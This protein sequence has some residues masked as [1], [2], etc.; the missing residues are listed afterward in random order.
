MPLVYSNVLVLD[1]LDSF[2][3]NL[4]DYL[5]RLGAQVRVYRNTVPAQ[6]LPD[7]FDL[8]LLSP[9]PSRP[10]NAGELLAVIDRFHQQKPVL[11]VCLGHQALVHYFGGRVGQVPPQHGK[12]DTLIHDGKTLFGGLPQQLEVARYHSLA[13]LEVPDSMEVS[14]RSVDGT[15]MAIRHKSLPIEGVQ[16]HPESVLSMKADAGMRMLQN[17]LEGKLTATGA[18]YTQLIGRLQKPQAPDEAFFTD[19]VEALRG[20]QLSE[21]QKLVLLTGLAFRLQAPAVM[22]QLVRVLL[23]YSPIKPE[24]SLQQ[25]GIDICGTGGSGL[26]RLNTST[27]SALLLSG[28]GVPI[29]KHGNKA[30]SGRFGSFDLL[31]ALGVPFYEGPTALKQA[32]DT[33]KLAMIY[34]RT[35]HP[36]VGLLAGSRSRLAVP[37]VFNVLG[38]LLNPYQP[39]RQFIGTAF[40]DRMPLIAEVAGRLGKQQVLVVRGEDGLDEISVSGPTRIVRWAEGQLTKD[41]LTP[42]DFG[43]APVPLTD[44][45]VPQ[46]KANLAIAQ[47]LAEGRLAGD[48]YKLVAINAAYVYHRYQEP[49]GLPAAFEKMVEA[50]KAGTIGKQLAAYSQAVPTLSPTA[51]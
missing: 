10:E 1:N 18:G 32:F 36:V 28:L 27:L 11:G 48:H 4:V 12:A 13:A 30:A 39:A 24:P 51:V 45:L 47:E 38:P 33:T 7:D 21:D 3:Y 31:E 25:T 26:P 41:T 22:E 35:A 2:T 34:A 5:R 19:Y 29:L 40:A 9:G 46:P 49:V 8:L 16:F 44:V 15:V 42:E 43:L 50:I 23:R 14:A 20:H 17:V 37:S 6:D